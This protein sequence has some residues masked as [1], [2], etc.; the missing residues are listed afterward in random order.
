MVVIHASWV[1]NF[2]PFLFFSF[3]VCLFYLSLLRFLSLWHKV[4][5]LFAFRTKNYMPLWLLKFWMVFY[6][7]RFQFTYL[8]RTSSLPA[9]VLS[10]STLLELHLVMAVR[11]HVGVKWRCWCVGVPFS[12]CFFL[13]FNTKNQELRSTNAWEK[14]VFPFQILTFLL[15]FMTTFVTLANEP[16][17]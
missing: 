5:F 16:F 6:V 9:V 12:A 10:Y 4:H 8:R 7:L 1:T 15:Q 11:R 17:F 3:L 14:G 2:S 13:H